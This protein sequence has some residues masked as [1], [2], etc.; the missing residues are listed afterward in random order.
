MAM[1]TWITIAS[2]LAGLNV[3]L[4]VALTLVWLA[5]YRTFRTPLILGLAA[6]AVVML[7]ENAAALYFY[8][9]MGML[10]S[11]SPQAQQ[12]VAAMRAMEFLAIAFL[13]YVSLK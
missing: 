11:G 12:F 13:T 2:A 10:Y 9:S 6:F 8:F 4:L 7:V 5:N 1:G 3:L